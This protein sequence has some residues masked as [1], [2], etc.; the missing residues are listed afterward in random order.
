MKVAL[1]VVQKDGS[2]A[3]WMVLHWACQ[4]VDLKVDLM[5]HQLRWKAALLADLMD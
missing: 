4:M 2:M 3:Y 5:V 1:R